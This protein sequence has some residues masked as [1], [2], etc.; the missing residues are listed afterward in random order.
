MEQ[1]KKVNVREEAFKAI[2]NMIMQNDMS[3]GDKLPSETS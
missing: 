2:L 3:P 1:I